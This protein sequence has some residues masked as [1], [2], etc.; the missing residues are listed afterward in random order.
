MFN[1]NFYVKT[2][3]VNY[4]NNN[5]KWKTYKGIQ[6][7]EE[8]VTG[9][10]GKGKGQKELLC[11]LRKLEMLRKTWVCLVFQIRDCLG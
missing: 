1:F 5:S 10:A 9:G 7:S 11:F 8:K 6:S 3:I 2:F 4:K